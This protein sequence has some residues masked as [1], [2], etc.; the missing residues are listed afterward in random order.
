MATHSAVT[1]L[2]GD[3]GEVS[4]FPVSPHP[5]SPP[6][7]FPLRGERSQS[8]R[9]VPTTRS[10]ARSPPTTAL[11]RTLPLLA[12]GCLVLLGIPH[13]LPPT[14]S[15][16]L[17][18]PT[19]P[20]E[21]RILPRPLPEMAH[22]HPTLPRVIPVGV[23]PFGLVYDPVN[24]DLYV[25]NFGSSNVSV[26]DTRTNH[27]IASLQLTYGIGY[28]GCDTTSGEVY[29]G[30]AQDTIYVISPTSN[31]VVATISPPSP[32]FGYGM[33]AFD[34]AQHELFVN[35]ISNSVTVIDT[36]HNTVTH[37]VPVG[38]YPN[39][40][41]FDP[42]NGDVYVSNEGSENMSVINATTDQVV[43]NIPNV[44]PGSALAADPL[45]GNVYLETNFW[46]P[47]RI[48]PYNL[49][50]VNG[51]DNQVMFR[52][53]M[54]E[55]GAIQA[56]YDSANGDFYFTNRDTFNVSILNASTDRVVG[57]IPVQYWGGAFNNSSGGPVGIAYDPASQAVYV[58]DDNTNNVTMIPPYFAV[59]F[60]ES[61]L[62]PG[63][64][65]S[66]TWN[67]TPRSTDTSLLP[68]V[69]P[70]GTY[71]YSVGNVSGFRASRPAGNV[72]VNG[73]AVVVTI[74]YSKPG[75]AVPWPY[76]A[77][78]GS[79]AAAAAA[80]VVIFRRLRRRAR[81]APPNPPRRTSSSLRDPA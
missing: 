69:A 27:V 16:S 71:A 21:P 72:T 22:A 80:G 9:K 64:P 66:V 24:R 74:T 20:T 1:G 3:L 58:A 59:T 11:S 49:T 47:S 43:A 50:V 13:P 77:M 4:T 8:P 38:S 60:R 67:G 12:L 36:R 23:Y 10:R 39:G 18:H 2:R 65:W 40:I 62:P 79:V 42:A 25:G 56:A 53:S 75:N 35:S 63:T 32:N 52:G 44:L 51:S 73:S 14:A 41:A 31:T 46:L 34:S 29:V 5:P 70:N 19:L 54:P 17:P 68:F 15:L 57:N 81:P 55:K 26:I 78:G 7:K 30:N 37:E 48:P 6:G 33:M 61:G 45:T 76:V 28:L